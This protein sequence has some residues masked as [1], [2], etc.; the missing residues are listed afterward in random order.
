MIWQKH[1]DAWFMHQS[2]TSPIHLLTATASRERET[3][4]SPST[5]AHIAWRWC[6][7][8]PCRRQIRQSAESVGS[9]VVFPW[10]L[11]FDQN[12]D[13]AGMAWH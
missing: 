9:K 8:R 11:S 6:S 10:I 3:G 7:R 1:R 5:E 4:V 12:A 2:A 13:K